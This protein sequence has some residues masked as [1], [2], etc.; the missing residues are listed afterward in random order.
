MESHGIRFD[1]AAFDP[2]RVMAV[3]H[4]WSDHPLLSLGKLMD[5]ARRLAARGAVRAHDDK[6]DPSTDFATAPMTH[7]APL[8]PEET[9]RNIEKAGAWMA[10]HNVQND[11]EYRRLVDDVLEDV[12]PRV[13]RKDPGMYGRAGWIFITSPG[14]V[15][16]YHFDHEHNF[17]LQCLG[18]KTLHVWEPLDR[19][20][21][22]E[23]ALELFHAKWSRE[24]LVYREAIES[25]AHVFE[26]EP[27]M[28]GYMPSTAPHWVK[29]GD[30][31]SITASFTYYTRAIRRTKRLYRMNHL[32]RRL[33]LEPRPV[34]E[35][36]MRDETKH[37][38]FRA[39]E[40]LRAIAA[41]R[42]PIARSP[43]YAVDV[44]LN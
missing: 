14:A 16:P 8:S 31:P 29:N 44:P 22:T 5:L 4:G 11:P 9:I 36:R 20:V 41:L 38:L 25:R 24:G 1:E 30:G 12:R 13:E 27:G 2:H 35:S 32:L 37:A 19:E 23:R 42:S 17:I 28:G 39:Q 3:R 7:P 18:R 43:A 15:T 34:G 40:A 33:G 26:L 10:L 21:V 6:A